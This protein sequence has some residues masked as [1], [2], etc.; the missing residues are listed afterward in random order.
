MWLFLLPVSLSH[1]AYYNMMLCKSWLT[2]TYFNINTILQ[3]QLVSLPDLERAKLWLPPQAMKA[4]GI[5][6]NELIRVGF[7]CC[8]HR[9]P[10][11]SWPQLLQPQEYNAPS[12]K[13]DIISTSTMS[14]THIWSVLNQCHWLQAGLILCHLTLK[15]LE[16]LHDFFFNLHDSFHKIR[17]ACVHSYSCVYLRHKYVWGS[18]HPSNFKPWKIA[19]NKKLDRPRASEHCKRQKNIFPWFGI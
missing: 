16:N 18:L 8:S 11:P 19:P 2:V 1:T 12:E 6:A 13:N 4:I 9:L 5:P 7:C 3:Q 10:M 17:P 15:R 14:V